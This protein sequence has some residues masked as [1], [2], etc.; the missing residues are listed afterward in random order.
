MLLVKHRDGVLEAHV[1]VTDSAGGPA[2]AS[3]L[4]LERKVR[5]LERGSHERREVRCESVDVKR[6]DAN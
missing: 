4:A 6:A 2:R 3:A 5:E 1:V